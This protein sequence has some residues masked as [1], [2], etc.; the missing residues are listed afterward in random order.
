MSYADFR[1]YLHRLKANTEDDIRIHWPVIDI[2]GVDA[3]DHHSNAGLQLVD[4]VASAFANGVEPDRYGNCEARYAEVLRRIVYNR[5][6]NYFSYGVKFYPRYEDIPISA[7][8]LRF[9]SLFR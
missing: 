1:G 2:N 7:D 5:N 3:K 4:T 9:I 8:Q 6:R